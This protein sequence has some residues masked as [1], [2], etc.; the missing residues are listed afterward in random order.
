MCQVLI[1]RIERKLPEKSG[2]NDGKKWTLWQWDCLVDV[3]S[4]GKEAVRR[5]KTFDA[6][7]AKVIAGAEKAPVMV[8]CKKQGEEAPF[9]YLAQPERKEGSKGQWHNGTKGFGKSNRQ[10]AIECAMQCMGL[11]V[12]KLEDVIVEAEKILAWLEGN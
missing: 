7:L 6:K 4:S 11:P 10:I 5:V 8:D 2:E 9:Q 12:A 3:D 1:K